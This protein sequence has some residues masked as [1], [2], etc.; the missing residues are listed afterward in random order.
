MIYKLNRHTTLEGSLEDI[1]TA[2]L[3]KELKPHLYRKDRI[4]ILEP[5]RALVH[6][7][8]KTR[9]NLC[10]TC[11]SI[12]GQRL[13][14]ISAVTPHFKSCFVSKVCSACRKGLQEESP[15]WVREY[16]ED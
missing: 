4:D 6:S 11:G 10:P 13:A 1:K 15:A 12:H 7:F 14:L 3:S 5:E 9:E 16:E 2:L 8:Y